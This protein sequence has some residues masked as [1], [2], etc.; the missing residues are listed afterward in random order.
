MGLQGPRAD[1]GR[2]DCIPGKGALGRELVVWFMFETSLWPLCGD[3]NVVGRG[4][5]GRPL[6][7]AGPHL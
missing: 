1:E 7:R 2:L 3:R 5:A 4:K 6:G